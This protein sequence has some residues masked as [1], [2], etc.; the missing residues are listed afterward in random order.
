[1]GSTT[2]STTITSHVLTCLLRARRR[3]AARRPA[4]KRACSARI[5]SP[6]RRARNTNTQTNISRRAR[7]RSA[8]RAT[9]A[10]RQKSARRTEAKGALRKE[11]YYCRQ[12]EDRLERREQKIIL[13]CE[14]FQEKKKRVTCIESSTGK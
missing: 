4:S 9:C 8:R 2:M 12:Q 13:K 14:T 7:K 1:M 3:R 10:T 11:G 5:S 6:M